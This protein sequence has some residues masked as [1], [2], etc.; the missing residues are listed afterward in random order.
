MAPWSAIA[1][2]ISGLRVAWVKAACSL[3][4]AASGVPAG[5]TSPN[6]ASS[7]S[8]SKP[9]SL[10]VGIVRK[11][12]HTLFCGHR[13]GAHLAGLQERQDRRISDEEE[14]DPA[15]GEIDARGSGAAVWHVHHRRAG[16]RLEHFAEQVTAGAGA[17]RGEAQ[18]AGLGLGERH[19]LRQRL[20]RAVGRDRQHLRE[21]PHQRD[22]PEILDRIVG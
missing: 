3:P 6:Q 13:D 16:P 14:I 17:L 11:N 18:A 20:R 21:A 8:P 22:R 1:L 19:Q 5:A 2:T 15:G 9:A 4:I 12:R 7:A 10:V